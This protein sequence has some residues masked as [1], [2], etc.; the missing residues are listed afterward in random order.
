MLV[1]AARGGELEHEFPNGVV[2]QLV[3]RP[4]LLGH[5]GAP[6]GGAGRPGGHRRGRA[7]ARTPTRRA[8]RAAPTGT[9]GRSPCSTASTGSSPTSRPSS[10]SCSPST[11][12][13]GPT[14][15]RCASC[16]TSRGAS[17]GCRC[18]SW[19]PRAPARPAATRRRSTS[20]SPTRRPSSSRRCRSAARAR[21]SC[22]ARCSA[23]ASTARSSPPAT[24]RRTATRSS[25]ASSPTPCAPTASTRAAPR[26]TASPR[27]GRRRSPARSSCASATSPTP[28]RRW[29]ARSRSSGRRRRCTTSPR[30]PGSS[31]R[32]PRARRTSCAA[33]TSSTPSPDPAFVHPI[34]RSAIYADIPQAERGGMH[35]AAARVLLAEGAQP[36]DVAPHLLSADAAGDPEV[37]ATLR[38]AAERAMREGAPAIGVRFLERALEEPPP[39]ERARRGP[40]RA[41]ARAAHGRRHR[42]GGARR[43]SAASALTEDPAVRARRRVPLARALAAS[44]GMPAAIAALEEGI[45][46]GRARSTASSSCAS[47]ASWRRSAS[48]ATR[49]RRG[50]AQRLER[51]RDLRG[52]HGGRVPRARQ[53]RP[54][55]RRS[56]TGPPPEAAELARRAVRGGR[57]P[58]RGGRR[59]D[60][61]A[62]RALRPAAVRRGRRRPRRRSTPRSPTRASAAR[63]SASGI[64]LAD[65]RLHRAADRRHDGRRERGPRDARRL[66]RARLVLADLRR[67]DRALARRARRPRRRRGRAARVRRAR[68]DAPAAQRVAA[69]AR[70]RGAAAAPGAVRRRPRRPRRGPRAGGALE[71]P[72]PRDRLAV[73]GR[74]SSTGAWA[75]SPRPSASRPSSSRSRA[76]GARGRRS[77]ARCGSSALVG[78]LDDPSLRALEEAVENLTAS[79]AR[80]ETA[81]ALIDLGAAL[82]RRGRRTDAREPLRQG[83]ELARACHALAL[84]ET[85]HQELIAAGARPRRLQFS[86][87]EALTASE[88]R[89]AELA[90][91]GLGNREI[92]QTLFV[93]IKTVENHL[94]RAYQKLG[95]KSRGELPAAL[96]TPA[97]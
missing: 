80:L 79:P 51:Y 46:R 93:T 20:S 95:I 78:P 14:R 40:R 21:A 49:S 81:R 15:R 85:G 27:S 74:A 70:A 73:A 34:V 5:A 3:E 36:R 32:R 86:G 75:T 64:V 97:P 31:R 41:R 77:A 44:D 25:C 43:S 69:A 28:R 65:L 66:R 68:Q 19:S 54:P 38:A 17:R 83:V 96:G 90:A 72:R 22:C 11:T 88:R 50:S 92:A 63:S 56:A 55:R 2:R 58:A 59:V 13:S 37:V 35:A 29:P 84:A 76:A 18:S 12:S 30:W 57:A 1:L 82:R 52:R 94:A 23:T 7:G 9:T 87:A 26:P 67:G 24:A 8:G 89:V 42:G 91:S 62:P 71:H 16:T 61:A 4:L 60:P 33:S 45:A 10:R 39:R 48:C 47:R 53:P 6:R